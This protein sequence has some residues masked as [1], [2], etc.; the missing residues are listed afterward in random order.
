MK[1]EQ[2]YFPLY[3]ILKLNKKVPLE[4]T[5]L[6]FEDSQVFSVRRA[7]I[8]VLAIVENGTAAFDG[9][10]R[11]FLEWNKSERVRTRKHYQCVLKAVHFSLQN[12]S[13][14][15]VISQILRYVHKVNLN[16]ESNL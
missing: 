7:I 12:V 14:A 5:A 16:N 9:L 10:L 15:N 2:N 1:S 4:Y 3:L 13:K 8:F 6:F 11:L